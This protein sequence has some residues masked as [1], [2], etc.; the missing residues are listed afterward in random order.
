MNTHTHD[1]TN[2]P[3][4]EHSGG[5]VRRQSWRTRAAK[6]RGAQLRRLRSVGGPGGRATGRGS[7]RTRGRRPGAEAEARGGGGGAVGGEL[8]R[9]WPAGRTGRDWRREAGALGAKGVC[10]AAG[11][12]VSA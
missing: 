5:N 8:R 1:C 12:V 10:A 6:H 11:A 7:P 4:Q 3:G 9:D 2:S